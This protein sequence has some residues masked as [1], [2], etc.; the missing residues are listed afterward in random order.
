MKLEKITVGLI[1]GRHN[2]PVSSYIFDKVEDMFD[3]AGIRK[4]I[5]DFI[6]S[7]V[8]VDYCEDGIVYTNSGLKHLVVY[9]TGLTAVACELVD[10][11]NALGVPLT[12]MHYDRDTG[13]YRPQFLGTDEAVWY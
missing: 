13:E 12:L 3:Y 11:C 6:R 9:V 5:E 7:E 2:M 8:G 10:A 1:E 4:H